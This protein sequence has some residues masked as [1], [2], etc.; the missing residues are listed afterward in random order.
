V[1][2]SSVA[3]TLERIL[4]FVQT[5]GAILMSGGDRDSFLQKTLDLEEKARQPAEALYVG[6]LGGTGVGKSTLINALARKVISSSSDRR[7]FTD[8]AVVYRHQDTPRGLEKI[9]NLI[10]EKDALHDS[11]IIKDLVLLDLPD[12]DSMEQENCKTVLEILSFLDSVVWVVSPEKYADAVFYGF[13]GQ[14]L[15]NTENFTFVINKAD[16]LIEDDTPDPL[17]KLKEVL[18]DFTFRLKHEAGIEQPRVFLISAAHEV[19]GK[20]GELVLQDEFKRFRNFLMVHRDAKE[21]ASVK[22]VNLIEETRHLLNGLNSVISPEEKKRLLR[23]IHEMQAQAPLEH[24]AFGVR[25]QDQEYKLSRGLISFL[26]NEDQSIGPVSLA[27]RILKLG[28]GAGS[29][30]SPEDMDRIFLTIA[31]RV[32]AKKRTDIEKVSAQLDSELLL[33][34]PRMQASQSQQ[35]AEDLMNRAV[36]EVST[37]LAQKMKM[38]RESLAGRLLRWRRFAQ[39]LILAAP[40][41]VLFVKLAGQATVEAWLEHPSFAGGLKIVLGFV[42]SLFSSDGLIGLVVLLIC[43]LFLIFY[44]AA[45]RIRK[46]EKD[47][48]TLAVSAIRDLGECLDAATHQMREER[49]AALQR[50]QESIDHLNALSSTFNDTIG[51]RIATLP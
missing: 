17:N 33:A 40:V 29:R 32:S 25:L 6:I 38:R 10:R 15:I 11:D 35:D 4:E 1:N 42:T 23:D 28:R 44:L 24:P 30:Q 47:A 43:Q 27:M 19:N 12:F 3:R 21:I 20:Y 50:I 37:L 46:I 13:V 2:R 36:D 5:D 26:M 45:K 16:Q 39:K 14:T 18:G 34:F 8:R 7:P 41:L 48:R 51:Y 31:Q 9:S 49:K 22:T